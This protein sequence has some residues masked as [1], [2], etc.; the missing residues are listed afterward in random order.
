MLRRERLRRAR[1][2]HLLKGLV[3]AGWEK[4]K[5][6]RGGQIRR[7]ERA[8]RLGGA[9]NWPLLRAL[10]VIFAKE[11]EAATGPTDNGGYDF[12]FFGGM[13]L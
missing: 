1:C 8:R 9:L 6:A 3:T 13:G 2:V 11:T 4:E 5:K 12:T 10:S 7:K